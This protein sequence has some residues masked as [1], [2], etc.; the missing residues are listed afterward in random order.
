MR[1]SRKSEEA[2]KANHTARCSLSSGSLPIQVVQTVA[3]QKTIQE[4]IQEEITLMIQPTVQSTVKS[5][6]SNKEDIVVTRISPEAA[7]VCAVLTRALLDLCQTDER[8]RYE[9]GKKGVYD[10]I[11]ARQWFEKDCDE[12]FSFRWCCVM[13]ELDA[14]DVLKIARTP[15]EPLEMRRRLRNVTRVRYNTS[16]NTPQLEAH[17]Q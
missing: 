3:S 14:K 8:F 2:K 10:G 17:L 7:L 9:N 6:A 16:D 11:S 4:Q 15:G 1:R 13:L 5:F 12:P